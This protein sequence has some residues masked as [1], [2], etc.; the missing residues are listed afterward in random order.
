V[1]PG[2]RQGIVHSCTN[3]NWTSVSIAQIPMGQGV[4]VTSLQMVMAMAA[5]ANNGILMRPMLVNRLEESGGKVVVQYAPEPIRRLAAGET[6]REMVQALKTVPTKEGTAVA[7]HL[8]H[9][10]VAGKTGTAQKVE[11][12]KYV[13]K[14]YTSFIGFFP[15]DNPELCISVVMDEPKDRDKDGHYVGHFGGVIDGPVFHNI[16]ERAAAYLNLKPDIA[17]TP[18]EAQT[19]TAAASAAQQ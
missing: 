2:E 15:A 1:L 12:G 13:Q 9:Y 8:D 17:P 4:A 14:F 10:T 7:A 5:I 11:H 19:L 18:P 3:T 16:A 6:I